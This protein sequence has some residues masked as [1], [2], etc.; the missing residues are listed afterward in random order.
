M[1]QIWRKGGKTGSFKLRKDFFLERL[2]IVLFFRVYRDFSPIDSK[3][4][5]PTYAE[6]TEFSGI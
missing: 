3:L 6:K 1:G 4:A 5:Y 2:R